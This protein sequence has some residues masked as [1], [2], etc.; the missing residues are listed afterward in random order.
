MISKKDVPLDGFG[1]RDIVSA[2]SNAK[3]KMFRPALPT[4]ISSRISRCPGS[5]FC[6]SIARVRLGPELTPG[7]LMSKN[8]VLPH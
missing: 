3:T 7:Y 2:V 1:T 5:L 4:K 8:V 6:G